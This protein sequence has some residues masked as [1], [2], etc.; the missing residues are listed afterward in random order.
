MDISEVENTA[1]ARRLR[2]PSPTTSRCL[3]KVDGQ[4]VHGLFDHMMKGE[5]EEFKRYLSYM[6][7]WVH[8]CQTGNISAGRYF[9]VVL[10]GCGEMQFTHKSWGQFQ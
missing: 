10:S 7:E 9:S 4:K 3:V 1:R 5:H 2:L 8:Q 6:G